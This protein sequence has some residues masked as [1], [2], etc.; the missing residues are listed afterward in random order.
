[1]D[2]QHSAEDSDDFAWKALASIRSLA[3]APDSLSGVDDAI[4]EMRERL[5][6]IEVSESTHKL[7]QGRCRAIIRRLSRRSLRVEAVMEWLERTGQL[8]RKT[9]LRIRRTRLLQALPNGKVVVRR[10]PLS[11]KAAALVCAAASFLV[12]MWMSWV[13]FAAEGNIELVCL[14]VILG[15][16]LGSIAGRALDMSFRFSDARNKVLQ[17]APQLAEGAL[18]A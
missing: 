1:M 7:E 10:Q 11:E 15:S 17:L 4:L 14:S 2:D 8:D 13:W 18:V 9:I 12:G 6:S 16:L 5:F 3:T